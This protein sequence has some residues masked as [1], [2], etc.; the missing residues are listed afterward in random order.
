MLREMLDCQ[1]QTTWPGWT[2]RQPI[3]TMREKLFRQRVAER[4]V[5]DAEVVDVDARLRHAR[6]AAG[7]KCVNRTIGITLRHPTPH[8][9]TTQ[10]L[11]L[12]KTEAREVVVTLDLC[13]RIPRQVTGE[14]EPERTT[15]F[16]VEMPLDNFAHPGIERF[17]WRQGIVFSVSRSRSTNRGS[18]RSLAR[19]GSTRTKVK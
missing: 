11:V 10:P 5:I 1:A 15:G 13:A 12:K 3:R 19:C 7:F 18:E 6:A 2:K 4:L 16:R 14:V 9:P 8:W 17:V